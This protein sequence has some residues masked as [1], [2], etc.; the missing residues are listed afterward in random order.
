MCLVTDAMRAAGMPC[1]VYDLGSMRV[2]VEDGVAKLPDRSRF[3]GSVATMDMLVRELAHGGNCSLCEAFAA[4]SVT[5]A[6]LV[7]IY[8]RK[9]SVEVSKDADL[10]ILSPQLEVQATVV[11]GEVVYHR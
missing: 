9:G 2:L 6:Q 8:D 5:P 7:G 11:A 4:A 10:V 1:G 3:A